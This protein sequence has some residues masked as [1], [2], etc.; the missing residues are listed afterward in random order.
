M[1]SFVYDHPQQT[2]DLGK[3]FEHAALSDLQLKRG[4]NGINAKGTRPS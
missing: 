4:Y 2:E 1:L 3:W